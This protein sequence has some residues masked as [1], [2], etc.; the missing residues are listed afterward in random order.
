MTSFHLT[1]LVESRAVADRGV[2]LLVIERDFSVTERRF[3]L[4]ETDRRVQEPILR[5][6]CG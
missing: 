5:G 2:K 1:E 3:M 6:V 4:L